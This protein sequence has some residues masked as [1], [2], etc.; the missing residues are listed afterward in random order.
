MF[1]IF[2]LPSDAQR[3][4]KYCILINTKKSLTMSY[5]LSSDHSNVHDRLSDEDQCGPAPGTAQVPG[6]AL[7]LTTGQHATSFDHI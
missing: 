4:V 5:F 1:D 6:L 3:S 2:N 7:T